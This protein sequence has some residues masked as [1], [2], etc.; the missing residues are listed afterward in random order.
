MAASDAVSETRRDLWADP[1][2][3]AVLDRYGVGSA[4][5]LG[6]G[7]EADVFALGA[8]RVLRVHRNP[9]HAAAAEY[10][11]RIGALYDSLD[12]TRVPFALPE[13]LEVHEEADA[14]WS[15][16]RRLPGRPFDAMLG[17]L[18]GAERA[19]A[20]RGYVDGAAA[21]GALGVPEGF[22]DGV[23]ELFTAERLRA[24]TWSE[25]LEARLRLQLER[26]EPVVRDRVA[27]LDR[28]VAAVLS[29]ARAEPASGRTLVH[30]DFFPGNVL[31]GDDLSVSAVLDL[32]WLTVVGDPTHDV[33]SAVAFWSVRPWARPGDRE[34][35]VA[36]A[37]R[38]LGPD[39][40]AMLARTERYEQ[41][42]FAFVAEDPHL[43]AWCVD[44]LRSLAGGGTGT[45][46]GD[47]S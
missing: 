40:D 27:D 8:D 45:V 3:R 26:G 4:D 9:D 7:G 13:V 46:L 10:V 47:G 21:F 38:H 33:R 16:E 28:A 1:A 12:R 32:G 36:A 43:F 31:F 30:G 42:R 15:I 14:T 29:L 41:A 24:T 44:G 39:V 37:A 18:S 35:L 19:T 5:H 25:L 17:E 23:G 2:R 11:R 20:I 22:G 6:H 34:V